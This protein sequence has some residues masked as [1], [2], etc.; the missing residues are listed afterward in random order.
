MNDNSNK[1][2]EYYSTADLSLAT[3]LFLSFTLASIDSTNPHRAEF[4]FSRSKQL[5]D[6]VEAFW[7]KELKVEPQ[8]YFAALRA[9][10]ARLYE[11]TNYRR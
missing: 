8:E 3:A 1:T 2:N 4:L 6:T 11:Y 5:D 7:R 10:K 9:I